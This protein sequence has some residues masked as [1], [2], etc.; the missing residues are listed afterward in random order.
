VIAQL[1]DSLKVDSEVGDSS[2]LIGCVKDLECESATGI[3][4]GTN[5]C[6]LKDKVDIDRET[7]SD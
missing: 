6:G 7:K 1:T 3:H 5:K 4:T 2:K